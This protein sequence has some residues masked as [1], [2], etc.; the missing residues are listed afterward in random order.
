MAAVAPP[1]THAA[2]HPPVASGDALV[3][4]PPGVNEADAN[5][6]AVAAAHGLAALVSQPPV[7]YQ[8][9]I[10][11]LQ[12]RQ[13]LIKPVADTTSCAC[14]SHTPG[15]VSADDG[16][17]GAPPSGSVT[18]AARGAQR[19]YAAAAPL[20][21]A[22]APGAGTAVPTSE[23]EVG[24]AVAGFFTSNNIP[25]NLANLQELINISERLATF[26]VVGNV[27]SGV[28]GTVA[29]EQRHQSAGGDA[30]DAAES[31]GGAATTGLP[32]GCQP[33]P[34]GNPVARLILNLDDPRIDYTINEGKEIEH[35]MEA[36]RHFSGALERRHLAILL[37]A[38][39]EYKA[40]G[41]SQPI[42]ATNAERTNK[43][44]AACMTALAALRN[45]LNVAILTGPHKISAV[46]DF[47]RKLH[48]CGL[49]SRYGVMTTLSRA[50]QKAHEIED[51]NP[52][53]I[54]VGSLVGCKNDL[55]K[56]EDFVIS[57][58]R[59]GR[60]VVVI[61]DECDELAQGKGGN[62]LTV[63]ANTYMTLGDLCRRDAKLRQADQV[64]ARAAAAGSG[65]GGAGAGASGEAAP[66]S[67]H[68]T[69]E[70]SSDDDT[71]S[72]SESDGLPEGITPE[73][74]DVLR[75]EQRI[76]NIAFASAFM[77]ERIF[78]RCLSVNIT[79]TYLAFLLKEIMPFK[80]DKILP[81]LD[82]TRD[83]AYAGIERAEIPE[84]ANL[85]DQGEI[86]INLLSVPGANVM[87]K[88]FLSG[89][90]PYDNKRLDPAVPG[91]D[92]LK[93]RGTMLVSVSA[94]VKVAHGAY[95]V[96]DNLMA[97][98]DNSQEF[99][100]LASKTVVIAFTGME[101]RAYVSGRKHVKLTKGLPIESMIAQAAERADAP[102]GFEKI[103]V[104]GWNLFKRGT[105]LSFHPSTDPTTA[106]VP[107][108]SIFTASPTTPVDV[109][110]QRVCRILHCFFGARVPDDFRYWIA[111]P[112]DRLR[113]ARNVRL[114]MDGMAARQAD[115]AKALSCRQCLASFPVEEHGLGWATVGK[116]RV[117]LPLL[118]QTEAGRRRKKEEDE[119]EAVD[120]RALINSGIIA[121][122]E[123][124][125]ELVHS[126]RSMHATLSQNGTILDTTSGALY[127]SLSG[128][129]LACINKFNSTRTAANGWDLVLYEKRRMKTYLRTYHGRAVA[130]PPAAP[131]AQGQAGGSAAAAQ[132][133]AAAVR[134]AAPVTLAATNKR[135]RPRHCVDILMAAYEATP[136]GTL[137]GVPDAHRKVLYE[138][139]LN[140]KQITDWMYAQ[141]RKRVRTATREEES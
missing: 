90:H 32:T 54:F 99:K 31:T 87:L 41:S 28:P 124:V 136:D 100:H 82:L 2:A 75:R 125:L 119:A 43:S 135:P 140:D 64:A 103:I 35:G 72:A 134:A 17:V 57:S 118:D 30:D 88:K 115:P 15:Q 127:S 76:H 93:I 5:V 20:M 23:A 68:D 66:A 63:D 109:W 113:D 27:S 45:G 141:R 80:P 11:P 126:R 70:W 26:G 7:T 130:A 83:P 8:R 60:K 77:Q 116:S 107:L 9:R 59:G 139:G 12:S 16:P 91:A 92:G 51:S 106:W 38:F 121:A 94:K 111:A 79:A 81:I 129:A 46:L 33:A 24:G 138:A 22:V 19:V 42:L 53:Q 85:L 62:S 55:P 39:D 71:S 29:T 123:N 101:P 133:A 108:Y 104:V 84:G 1:S 40:H 128:W 74:R 49:S 89:N 61:I 114:L 37:G 73:R 48:T 13:R 6:T 14:A 86:N 50:M 122:G 105:S 132:A 34:Q 47:R 102:H 44:A 67:D 21:Q 56:L 65:D 25:L 98:I 96:S 58:E 95:E 120:L 10:Q 117:S 69:D 137:R 110:S 52:A 131:A 18:H 4:V 112:P 78:P 97:H 36:H 3:P